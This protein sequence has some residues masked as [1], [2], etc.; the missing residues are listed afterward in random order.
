HP[1]GRSR[2]GGALEGSD[3]GGRGIAP[4]RG[5]GPRP[6]RGVR[7]H[8][9]GPATVVV[10]EV[11]GPGSVAVHVPVLVDEVVFLLRPRDE[12]WVIDATVGMGGPSEAILSAA[13]SSVR[14][15]GLD[16]DPA[17]LSQARERLAS[18]GDR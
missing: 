9:R 6:V 11:V 16:A 18:F 8:A 7:A 2:S 14:L 5:M 15:L 12:G 13:G 4:V 1:A 3:P 10:R 17:A